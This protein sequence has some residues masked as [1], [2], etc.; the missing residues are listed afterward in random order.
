MY[1]IIDLSV[2]SD[3][4]WQCLITELSDNATERSPSW[5][6]TCYEIWHCNPKAVVSAVLANPNFAGQFNLCPYIN[7]DA[8]GKHQWSNVMSRNLAWQR[9]VSSAMV[10]A[11]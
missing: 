3:I 1:N 9:C 7:L 6:W 10:S 11:V 4:P 8:N 5:M 2:L